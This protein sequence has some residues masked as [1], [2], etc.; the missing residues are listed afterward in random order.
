M[1]NQKKPEEQGSEDSILTPTYA[2]RDMVDSVPKHKLPEQG[3]AQ[4]RPVNRRN[5]NF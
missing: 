5:N 1:H 4:P 3:I 2:A